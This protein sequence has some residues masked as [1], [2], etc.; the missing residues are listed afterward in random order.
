[1]ASRIEIETQ[2]KPFTKDNAQPLKFT[3]SQGECIF[4]TVQKSNSDAETMDVPAEFYKNSKITYFCQKDG[5]NILGTLAPYAFQNSNLTGPVEII[6]NANNATSALEGTKITSIKINSTQ[7]GATMCKNCKLLQEAYFTESD[8]VLDF[9][10]FMDC[11]ALKKIVAPRFRK[12]VK[13]SVPW[14]IDLVFRGTIVLSNCTKDQARQI[15]GVLDLKYT[16][17]ECT[18]GIIHRE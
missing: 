15:T 1:M 9:M 2:I 12:I 4:H 13:E 8:S 7:T 5:V 11:N 10:P 16:D 14:E 18:D 3:D 6:G 17:I